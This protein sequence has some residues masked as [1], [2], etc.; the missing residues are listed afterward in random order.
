M[1][2]FVEDHPDPPRMGLCP[3]HDASIGSLQ[4]AC[5]EL[6]VM[7][8]R[9]FYQLTVFSSPHH[10]RD[11]QKLNP[12]IR[13]FCVASRTNGMQTFDSQPIHMKGF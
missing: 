8:C 7:S 12:K 13:K 1:E 11:P 5:P 4:K 6:C 3:D 2:K 10:Q 9:S